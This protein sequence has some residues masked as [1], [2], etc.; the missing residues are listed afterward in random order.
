MLDP[1]LVDELESVPAMDGF[2]GVDELVA[3]AQRLAAE[4]S[5]V[6][7]LRRIGTS[8][9]G[10]PL[11]CL[12]VGSG[13]HHAVV[14]GMPHPNEPIGGLT[15][16]HLARRICADPALRERLGYTWHIVPCID[17]DGTRLNEGWFEG[18]FTRT[19]YARNFY[20]PAASEQVEWTFPFAYK[21]AYFDQ[22]LPETLALMRLIDD[23]RPTFMCSLHNGEVGGVYYYL[24]RPEPS[25]YPVLQ[26]IPAHLSLPLDTGEPE[27]PFI[28]RLDTAIYQTAST[29]EA[30]DYAESAGVDPLHEVAGDSSAAYAS[31][32]GTLTLVSELPYLADKNAG[33]QRPAKIGYGDLL[34][35]QAAG[36]RE[37]AWLLTDTLDQVS[38]DLVTDSPFLRATRYFA[39]MCASLPEMN[40][41]RAAV[42]ES[43][44]PATVA[45]Q[46]SCEDLVHMFRLR[47]GGMLLRALDGEVAIGNGTPAIRFRR[48]ALS[49]TFQAWCDEAEEASSAETIP[50]K[51]LVGTQYAAILAVASHATTRRK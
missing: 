50:I 15:A 29:E 4:Y 30:Y 48:A 35:S 7:R 46:H 3:T 23:T 44:R 34:R 37:L 28:R 21:R 19:L 49:E 38:P 5:D 25:L 40:E 36:L 16:V 43:S 18:P 41:R 2:A 17:P 13:E 26:G 12:T 45:E 1:M 51:K 11:V 24:S 22:V 14:F 32:Y 31:R 27:A 10:E 42:A 39:P 9:L 20:R 47:Y 6:A 8:R 33:D